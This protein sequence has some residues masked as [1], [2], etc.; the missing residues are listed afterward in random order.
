MN[1]S[2]RNFL[3]LAA[4]GT[5]AG[6]AGCAR[7]EQVPAADQGDA[8]GEEPQLDLRK[9]EKLKL[10][11]G[12]W[13]YDKVHDCYYQLGLTYCLNPVSASYE[14]L[15]IFV[16]GAY[17]DAEKSG[18]SFACTVK[19]DASKGGF[20]PATAPIAMPINSAHLSAQASPAAYSYDGLARYLDA[21]LVYVY[22]GFRGRSGG[23]ESNSREM[24]PGG[25]PWPVADLK[26]AVRYLRYN[27]SQL[28]VDPSRIFVF[29]YGAGGGVSAT[30]GTTGDSALYA[31]Y[32]EAIGA[33]SYDGN[34]TTLSDAICGSASWCPITSFD[35]ANS[36]YEWMLGQRSQADSRAEGSWTRLLSQDLASSFGEY[37][38]GMDLR[39]EDDNPLTLAT[40]ED[41]SYADGSYYDYLMG[42][43][44]SS[45]ADFLTH[46]SFPYTHTPAQ[47]SDPCFPGDPNLVAE[48]IE[49]TDA[50]SEAQSADAPGKPTASGVTSV[51]STV[52]DSVESYLS[53]LNGDDRWIS[54]S[55]SLGTARITSLADF[56]AHCKQPTRPVGAFDMLDRSSTTNQLFGVGDQSTLHFDATMGQLLKDR[57]DGYAAAEGFDAA[58]AKAWE[59]DLSKLD[60][61]ESS[62]EERL[63]AMN[64]LYVLSGRYGGF[65]SASVAPHWRIS[66]GLFQTES[67]LTGELNLALAL[68]HYD[69]VQ[70]VSYQTVWGRGF[71]LAEREGDPQ[72][73]LVG[74]IVSCCPAPAAE[75]TQEQERKQD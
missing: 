59:E 35:T 58:Y 19:K 66:S 24:Y 22:A 48:T 43:I 9:Y 42:T 63:N 72:D 2:R 69:S 1:V 10:D 65:G 67:A 3:A 45:A 62:M 68:R 51:Q 21:G 30:L 27:A 57:Q 20:T 18:E 28:P 71:E 64:P 50:A 37:V 34:G 53:T 46:T 41:G 52:Y 70:D 38:N 39:D 14:S 54:Y 26:A 44:R 61:L 74:W 11:M 36:S 23:F 60:S 5:S 33:A 6:L 15:A 56:V 75:A 40:I 32:L 73:N 12:A 8:Q 4:A 55:S 47:M 25:A 31:K 13:K 17:F 29:G 7:R 49:A 16:P